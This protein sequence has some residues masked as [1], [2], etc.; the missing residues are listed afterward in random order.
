MYKS[1]NLIAATAV[2]FLVPAIAGAQDSE[3]WNRIYQ[4]IPTLIQEKEPTWKIQQQ[5]YSGLRGIYIVWKSKQGLIKLKMNENST[6]EDASRTVKR[7]ALISE[8]KKPF[9][10]CSEEG[11]IWQRSTTRSVI[12]RRGARYVMV[13]AA[14]EAQAKRMAGYILAVW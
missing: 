10:A 12:C 5:Q 2:L 4:R 13:T 8:E 7:L 14:S 1:I 9:P 3:Y 6:V 11:Y